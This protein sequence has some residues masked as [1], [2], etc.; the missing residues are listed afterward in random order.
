MK[1]YC[2]EDGRLLI[3]DSEALTKTTAAP[4]FYEE[5]F[6]K[7]FLGFS[8][9]LSDK[10][11]NMIAIKTKNDQLVVMAHL[12]FLYHLENVGIIYRRGDN[13]W[14]WLFDDEVEAPLGS[15]REAQRFFLRR[16]GDK[17]IVF[18]TVG[19]TEFEFL[20][21]I[22]ASDDMAFEVKKGYYRVF[23]RY[24][25]EVS[26]E[27]TRIHSGDNALFLHRQQNG[28]YRLIATVEDPFFVRD[29]FYVKA[30]GQNYALFGINGD[31][32]EWLHSA[33]QDLWDFANHRITC[34]NICWK[35]DKFGNFSLEPEILEG[36]IKK[37]SWQFWKK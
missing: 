33:P 18:T 14:L 37:K 29:R 35:A 19:A 22:H 2:I 5:K 17:N 16:E 27:Y 34:G 11:D 25:Y 3:V 6:S 8:G 13:Y 23:P 15:W 4:G 36:P 24:G 12:E 26:Q 28:T 9:K 20:S 21:Y 31:K 10:T 7:F 30:D 1:E 32:M